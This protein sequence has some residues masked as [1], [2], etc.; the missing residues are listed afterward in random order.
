[1]LLSKFLGV[2]LKTPNIDNRAHLPDENYTFPHRELTSTV[3][4]QVTSPGSGVRVTPLFKLWS[5][6]FYF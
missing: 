5:T 4:V 1:M 2:C 3:T 6:I